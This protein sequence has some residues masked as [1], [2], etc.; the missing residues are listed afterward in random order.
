MS[1]E[2]NRLMT[3][4][5]LALSAQDI[6]RIIEIQRAHRAQSASGVKPK[7]TKGAA[8]DLS[9]VKAALAPPKPTLVIPR[10]VR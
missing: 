4:D 10:R 7:R 9:A 8:V 6:D 5:P 1:D 2:L 3:L